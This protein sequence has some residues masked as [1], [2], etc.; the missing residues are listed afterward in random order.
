MVTIAT[1]IVTMKSTNPIVVPGFWLKKRNML[2][3]RFMPP[4][5]IALISVVEFH[6]NHGNK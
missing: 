6:C 4:S 1:T 2:N 3:S 5:N